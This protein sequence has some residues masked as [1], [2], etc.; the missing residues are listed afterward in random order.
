MW[1]TTIARIGG[2][3]TEERHAET[4]FCKNGREKAQKLDK[5]VPNVGRL[6]STLY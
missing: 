5:A 6:L 4:F 3:K 2:Q 1:R